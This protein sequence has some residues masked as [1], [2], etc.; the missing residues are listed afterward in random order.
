MSEIEDKRYVM[1]DKKLEHLK[2]MRAKSAEKARLKKEQKLKE[3]EESAKLQIL[4]E[5]LHESEPEPEEI[6]EP[7]TRT[8][9]TPVTRT[10][11]APIYSSSYLG[12]L[13]DNDVSIIKEFVDVRKAEMK[14]KKWASRKNEVISEVLNRLQQPQEE[15]DEDEDDQHEDVTHSSLSLFD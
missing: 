2:N 5:P 13:S 4:S 14:Q 1:T 6:I 3:Q 9:K 7:P 15:E 12:S 8:A 11:T 10:K